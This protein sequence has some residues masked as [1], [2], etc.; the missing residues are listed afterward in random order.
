[1]FGAG[2]MGAALIRT[3]LDNNFEVTLW[4]RTPAKADA[5]VKAGAHLAA[6]VEEALAASPI[7]VVCVKDYEAAREFL[8]NGN[9]SHALRGKVL[10]QLCTGTPKDARDEQEWAR[11]AGIDYIDGA[12][13]AIPSQMGKP[14]TP[15]YLSGSKTGFDRSEPALR[16]MAGNLIYLG[17]AV[18]TAAA[19]DFAT[20]CTMFGA[21]LGFFHGVRIFE[22]E[23]LGIRD[24]GATIANLFPLI[25]GMIQHSSEVIDSNK[26][27]NPES[28]LAI[29]DASFE[30]F[31]RHAK[32]AA[33]GSEFPDFAKSLSGKAMQAG[34]GDEAFA[35]IIKVMRHAA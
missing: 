3:L 30:L 16:A 12:I 8:R 6:G 10:V 24:L 32:Q 5:L 25:G 19:W 21:Q 34:Y 35:A 20:L 22:S 17:E 26:Y 33:I 7:I 9:Y 2:A 27:G 31:Q 1:V 18:G 14:D 11:R 29:C 4:N 23:S 13:M 28:S 15:I